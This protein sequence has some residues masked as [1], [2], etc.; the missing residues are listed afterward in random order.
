MSAPEEEEFAKLPLQEQFT[1]KNWKARKGGYEIAAAEFAKSKPNS[2][3]V[4]DFILDSSLWKGAVGDS[5]VAAQQEGLSAYNAFL[6][7]AGTE[8]A[9]KTRSQTVAP[10]VEKG[11]IGR[12]AAKAAA[13]ESLLLLIEL[14]KADAII[15]ELLPFLT[16][17]LPKIVVATL[18]ALKEIYHAYGCRIVEPKPVVKLL[19]KVF[20]H[21]DKNVRAE[22]QALT[23][24]LYRW[25]RDAMK[26]L[27]WGELKEMQQKD[28][29]KL[30]EPVKAEPTPK[31]E[32]LLRTQQAAAEEAEEQGAAEEDEAEEAVEIDLEEEVVAV[33][34]AQKLPKDLNER[35][36]STK[37]KDR[38][39]VLEES[40]G[41]LNV[42]AIKEGPFDDLMRG[43]AKSMKDANI[44]VVAVAANVIEALAKGLRKSFSRYRGVVLASM[45]ERF[46]E[47]KQAVTDAL[48][49]ACDAVFLSTG[50]TE[51]LSDVL[52]AT[53]NKNPQVKEHSA[54]FLA[55]SL[56]LTKVVPTLEQTKEMAEAGKKL[57]GEGTANLR[58]VGA[59][60][61]GVLWKI[62][63]DKHML[64]HLDGVEEIRK[65]KIKEFSDAAE[66]KSKWKPPKA[67]APPPKAAG[68]PG[69]KP[70]LGGKRPAPIKKPAARAA[71]PPLMADEPVSK[72]PPT[73][74]AAAAA[75]GPA[76]IR[77]PS[78]GLKAPSGLGKPPLGLKAPTVVTSATASPKRQGMVLEDMPVPTT[79]RT[80]P[81][82]G[83][84][85][86][87]PLGRPA[88]PPS[89]TP[90]NT[91][92]ENNNAGLRD[93]DRQEIMSLQ[94]ENSMLRDQLS[95]LR[96][97]KSKMSSQIAELQVQ[98]AQLI[99]DHTRDVLQIKAKETQL[100][101]ARSDAEN[102]V[103][104]A[105]SLSKEIERLKREMSR[106]NRDVGRDSP[107]DN[108]SSRSSYQ[109]QHTNG[110][111]APRAYSALSEEGKEN[112]NYNQHPKLTGGLGG[113]MRPTS[114][115]LSNGTSS[116]DPTSPTPP[117]TSTFGGPSAAGSSGLA[118]SSS[119]AGSSGVESW[120]RA[121]EVTQN[122]KARIEMMKVSSHIPP[123]NSASAEKSEPANV[124]ESRHDRI[125]A[126]ADGEMQMQRKPHGDDNTNNNDDDDDL[127]PP[128]STFFSF[129]GKFSYSLYDQ[130][131]AFLPLLIRNIY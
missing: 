118:R 36:S 22:S 106:L 110:A 100:V 14:D 119:D 97:D 2:P 28:L 111:A 30:F 48:S 124:V 77:P 130:K 102:A 73:P 54:K 78:M 31:Q 63:G 65:T 8:G 120:K 121:A 10:I 50:L 108:G 74:R 3:I 1:H 109:H 24:E 40:L 67:A 81:G 80:G 53:K 9:R 18:N 11:L 45:L 35:L 7:K 76:G 90:D 6:A 127:N 42:K 29:E 4:R 55:R 94:Q 115:T 92:Y 84:L 57:L 32:R 96:S 34:V 86:G 104:R 131:A 38:K 21:A 47:K 113:M 49:A 69:K 91:Q 12:P 19:P 56:R 116:P 60:I 117:R 79:P 5:N 112:V 87:R 93:T 27:F 95:G 25:L 99:E 64:G 58:D 70:A 68:P 16:H 46:K 62:M 75:K 107:V 122:L 33:D 66:V 13:V 41:V 98:N 17:K 129:E 82:R 71:S 37:W 125:W 59:E 105:N 26:P 52:E 128:Q 123:V 15:E 85:A 88:Q 126:G 39:E 44:M 101:R 89:P 114:R 43:C 103:E 61:L 72:P 83:G 23:V 20:G 51:I